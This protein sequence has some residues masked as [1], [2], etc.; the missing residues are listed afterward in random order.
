VRHAAALKLVAAHELDGALALS[1]VVWPRRGSRLEDEQVP[2]ERQFYSEELKAEIAS[3]TLP[4][5][6]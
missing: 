3:A 1:Y 2:T 5:R 4:A 6:R